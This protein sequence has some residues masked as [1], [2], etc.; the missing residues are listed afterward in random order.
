VFFEVSLVHMPKLAE[1]AL[2]FFGQCFFI[3]GQTAPVINQCAGK[4]SHFVCELLW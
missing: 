4:T 3:T 2:F 1:A